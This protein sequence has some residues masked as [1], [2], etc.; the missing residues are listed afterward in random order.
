[1]PKKKKEYTHVFVTKS[2]PVA[3][4]IDDLVDEVI[5]DNNEENTE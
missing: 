4:A 2:L 5:E 3:N 1:M